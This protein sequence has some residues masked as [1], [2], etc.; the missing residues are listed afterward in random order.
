M[1]PI[2][3]LCL[4]LLGLLATELSAQRVAHI[5]LN[6]GQSNS[7]GFNSDGH[8]DED[9]AYDNIWQLDC[10]SNGTTLPYDECRFVIAQDPLHHQCDEG[11]LNGI[12]V[13]W[14]RNSSF[15]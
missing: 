2:G 8:T 14:F 10:C 1:N 4:F 12:T 6:A 3:V 13:G 5:F 15:L 11:F 7:E 9:V